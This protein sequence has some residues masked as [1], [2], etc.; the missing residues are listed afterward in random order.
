MGL[1][2]IKYNLRRE[3]ELSVHKS[4]C[5]VFKLIPCSFVMCG[6][7]EKLL[8]IIL[9]PKVFIAPCT[10]FVEL[11]GQEAN[12]LNLFLKTAIV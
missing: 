6:C 10:S 12:E 4:F 1:I 3:F 5:T 9:L 11:R 7:Q 8:V 2:V